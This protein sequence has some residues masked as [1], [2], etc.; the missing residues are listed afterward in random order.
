[1][2]DNESEYL[3]KTARL[4]WSGI[5]ESD[6]PALDAAREDLLDNWERFFGPGSLTWGPDATAA[7]LEI[8]LHRGTGL[9]GSPLSR[10][11]DGPFAVEPVA[12]GAE[13]YA[14]D[15]G[16]RGAGLVAVIRH[17]GR[18]GMQYGLYGFAEAFLGIR[19]VHP[20]R[21][22]G[23]EVPPMP[24]TLHIV[25]RP[26]FPVRI[27]YETSHA[28]DDLRATTRRSSHFSDVG[29]W[30]WEDWA[31]NSERVC[32][33]VSWAVKNRANCLFFDD[34]TFIQFRDVYPDMAS[35]EVWRS[36]DERGLTTFMFLGPGW[37]HRPDDGY[38][39]QDFCTHEGPRVGGWTAGMEVTSREF[40]SDG[41][42]WPDLWSRHLCIE[43]DAFW[44]DQ[45]RWLD[46]AASHRDRL[47]GLASNW[48]EVPCGEGAVEHDGGQDH[49]PLSSDLAPSRIRT[50]ALS[51]GAG[52]RRCGTIPNV[53]KWNRYLA[54]ANG[55]TG[56][57]AYGL[58]PVGHTRTHWSIA[59][60]DDSLVAR[61]VAP[62]LPSDSF[63]LIYCLPNCNAAARVEGW[64]REVDRAN[65]GDGGNRKVILV[66]ELSYGCQGDVPIAHFSSLDRTDDDV[67]TFGPYR[68]TASVTGGTYTFHSL[69][70]LLTHY[71]LRSQW[72]GPGR[73]RQWLTAELSGATG[74]EEARLIR[75]VADDIL[76]VQLLEGLETGEYAAYYSLWGLNTNKLAPETIPLDAPLRAIVARGRPKHVRLVGTGAAD[77]QGIYTRTRT[78]PARR[79]VSSMQRRIERAIVS[80]HTLEAQLAQKRDRDFWIVELILPI[81]WTLAFL[82]SRLLLAESLLSYVAARSCFCQ[83]TDPVEHLRAGRDQSRRARA[84]QRRYTLLRPGFGADYPLEVRPE[85]MRRLELAFDSL[86]RDPASLANLDVC[87][88]VDAA[89]REAL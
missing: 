50:P 5:P 20:L 38:A 34:S 59:D 25:E 48:N 87:A 18:L 33:L 7:D 11:P 6:L 37:G 22:V 73:W 66:R 61:E 81:R 30:R 29:A 86:I 72:S 46:I 60:P 55:P 83:G 78:A 80:T 32:C 4:R 57:P 49:H 13:D 52:C 56:A 24:E 65:A 8:V 26:C 54:W 69:G 17:S 35:D 16:R 2:G 27:M 74:A 41:G 77:E 44:R 71:S 42:R 62:G 82:R 15:V 89:E 76:G 79:R 64:P 63:S 19:Y 28:A 12:L 9:S 67:R 68:S 31:G 47:L 70:W 10:S 53:T 23:P 58:P 88:F 43:G 36:V 21:D 75:D 85:T 14:L 84:E 51:T 45:K 39:P 40:W 3:M 1:M